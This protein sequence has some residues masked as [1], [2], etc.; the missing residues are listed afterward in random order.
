MGDSVLIT[1]GDYKDAVGIAYSIQRGEGKKLYRIAINDDASGHLDILVLRER[2]KSSLEDV[3]M[4]YTRGKIPIHEGEP[5]PHWMAITHD[6]IGT[7]LL[8]G[9]KI[10]LCHRDF[11]RVKQYLQFDNGQIVLYPY[12]KNPYLI[13]SSPS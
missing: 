8:K 4:D 10:A 9:H 7:N 13:L 12:A 11:K 1:D 6:R 3:I 2:F 5:C